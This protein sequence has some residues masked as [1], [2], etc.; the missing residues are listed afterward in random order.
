MDITKAV[1]KRQFAMSMYKNLKLPLGRMTFSKDFVAETKRGDLY[2]VIERTVDCVE[3]ITDNRYAVLHGSAER[4]IGQ[5]F[6]YASY[7]IC[8]QSANGAAGFGFQI[9]SAKAVLLKYGNEITF[10]CNG[11]K[12]TVKCEIASD[13]MIVSCRRGAV[14]V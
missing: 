3:K 8:F 13:T 10:E 9:K 1:F 12:E 11:Q 14:D 5:F 2:P 7:E 6:P 4:M